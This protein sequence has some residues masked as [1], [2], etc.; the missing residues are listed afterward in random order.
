MI[1]SSILD[2]IGNTPVIRFEN[3]LLPKNKTIFLKLEQF[4]PCCSI[5]DRTALGLI[6]RAEKDGLISKGSTLIETTSGNIGKSL[7][8]IG[9]AMGY[10]VIII[11]DKKVSQY[12]INI[13]TAYGA[14]VILIKNSDSTGSLQKTRI[15][16]VKKL[17]LDIPN[18]FWINQYDNAENIEYHS[19]TTATEIISCNTD[20]FVSAVG[21]GGHI[22]G[23]GKKIKKESRNI[24]V[25]GVDVQGSAIF[26]KNYVPY[27]IH[28]VG[29]EQ[30]A[31]NTKLEYLDKI[32]ILHDYLAVS[33]CHL[34]AKSYGI[35]MGGSGGLALCGTL[36][37]FYKS[38]FSKA[39]TI[40]PDTGGNYIDTI[41]NP[42]YL[43][44]KGIKILNKKEL[45]NEITQEC[46]IRDVSEFV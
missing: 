23:I 44:K 31:S 41:Y 5:K 15:N 45:I 29:L 20:L 32:T 42:E 1:Y 6:R 10:K 11:V 8:M 18:A 4:N 16:K 39:I 25:L 46:T 37:A 13:Y 35:L 27:A 28:G 3:D 2:T 21:T 43:S 7:A 19:S 33:M 17:L 38:N 14:E 40:I 26:E 12:T 30:R 9:A 34:V 24:T 36:L 22:C